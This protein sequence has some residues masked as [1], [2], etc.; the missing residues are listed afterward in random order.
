MRFK[1][2]NYY[3]L[4][5]FGMFLLCSIIPSTVWAF[6]F[7]I[8]EPQINGMLALTFPYQTHMGN[9]HISLTDPR[10]YFYEA[11]QEIGIALNISLKDQIS[12]QTAKAVTMVRG[13]I[14]F[15][16]QQQQ[17]QLVKPKIARLDWVKPSAGVDQGLVKQVTQ[18]VGQEL[19]IIV[20]LDIKQLTGNKLTPTLS[21]IKIKK[22][23]IEVSF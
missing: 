13:G 14:H 1:R 15:D 11:S 5:Q 8:S 16:N 21:D 18:L 3:S 2:F 9:S 4:S 10:P 17:L 22:Q 12:G 7:M 19:P 20:L 23:G 6:S